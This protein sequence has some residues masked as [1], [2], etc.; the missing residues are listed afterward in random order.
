METGV[1]TD[2][3]I[4]GKL[5]AELKKIGIEINIKIS[6]PSVKEEPKEMPFPNQHSDRMWLGSEHLLLILYNL[7]IDPRYRLIVAKEVSW[8]DFRKA[9]MTGKPV[10]IWWHGTI[11]QLVCMIEVLLNS[12]DLENRQGLIEANGQHH[13][14]V[15]KHFRNQSGKEFQLSVL[16]SSLEKKVRREKDKRTYNAVMSALLREWEAEK[17]GN[18]NSSTP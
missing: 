9:F 8:E 2:A 16:S 17:L 10:P 6:N 3:M 15:Q 12:D 18:K 13:K 1:S 7:L 5:L 4:L 14:L 11:A